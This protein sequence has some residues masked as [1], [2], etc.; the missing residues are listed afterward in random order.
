MAAYWLDVLKKSRPGL[1][2][3]PSRKR[4]PALNGYE[5]TVHTSD[6]EAGKVVEVAPWVV[7]QEAYP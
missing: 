6:E 3:R 7:G 1:P 5:E 2:P 4:F